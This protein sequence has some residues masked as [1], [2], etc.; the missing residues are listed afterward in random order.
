MRFLLDQNLPIGLC[1]LLTRLG[2]EAL[3]VEPLGLGAATDAAVWAE[4]RRREAVVVSKDSD[5]LAFAGSDGG[6]VRLRVGNCS[7]RVL[8]GIID[9]AWPDV[10]EKLERGERIVEVRA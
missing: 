7:N 5:F 8:F 4:A 6:L 2:H 10:V 3:H 9:R 1:A